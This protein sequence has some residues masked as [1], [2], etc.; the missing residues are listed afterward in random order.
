MGRVSASLFVS[1]VFL[2]VVFAGNASAD[3]VKSPRVSPLGEL[4]CGDITYTVV[5]PPG[6]EP[7][8]QLV[9]AN[10]SN[11]T[12]VQIMILDKASSFSQSMLTQCTFLGPDGFTD[13]FLIT[14][15]GLAATAA[16]DGSEH[17]G[18]ARGPGVWTGP[19]AVHLACVDDDALRAGARAVAVIRDAMPP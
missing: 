19:S 8:G 1:V 13:Y 6:L 16:R 7:V 12:S 11:S 5:S 15:V 9:T 2:A 10:G 17:R 4:V 18:E 14:P 3:P